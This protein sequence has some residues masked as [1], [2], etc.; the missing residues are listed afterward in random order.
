MSTWKT[1]IDWTMVDLQNQLF[2]LPFHPDNSDESPPFNPFSALL[3]VWGMEQ[4]PLFQGKRKQILL[5]QIMIPQNNHKLRA[6]AF[7]LYYHNHLWPHRRSEWFFFF[8]LSLSALEGARPFLRGGK[9]KHG[10]APVAILIQTLLE[11]CRRGKNRALNQY[12][13]NTA[14]G[15]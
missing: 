12:F 7:L 4:W 1:Q 15:A 2:V 14:D 9:F 3:Q 10:R 11:T 13:C 8:F 5:S 6:S